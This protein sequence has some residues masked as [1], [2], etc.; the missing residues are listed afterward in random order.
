[1]TQYLPIILASA[2]LA[3]LA[4]P[5]TRWMARR[6][7]MVDQPGLRKAH[8][9]PTPLLGGLAMYAGLIAAFLLLGQPGWVTEGVGILGGATLMFLTGL[10][11][12]R[13]G[14][15][16]R[17]KL[18]AAVVAALFLVA[19]GV[20]VRLFGAWWLDAPIT[21]LWVVG[22]THAANLM[23]NM[24]GLTAGLAAVASVF[25][26]VMAALEG[27][28]LVASLAAALLGATGG[29]LFYNFAPAVSF[30]GDAG[31]LTLGFL[32]A[33]LGIKIEF[34]H[35]PLGATWM[36]PILVLS[37]FIF[38]TTL[39][40]LS[41]LRRGRSPFQGGSDHTSHRLTQLGLSS[42]RAVLT[43]Y[44]GAI[45]LGALAVTL[46]RSPVPVANA[47][48]GLIVAAGVV[49]LIFFERI[50]PRLSGDPLIVL[51]PG[52]GGFAEALRIV[53]P[54]SRNVVVLLAPHRQNGVLSPAH[55]DVVEA[56]AG[57]A[58]AAQAVR[59]LLESGL[60]DDWP[61]AVPSL[62]NALKLHGHVALLDTARRELPP[63]LEVTLRKCKALVLGPGDPGGN[64]APAL[65][66]PALQA[67]LTAARVPIF[68]LTTEALPLP[69]QLAV[70]CVAPREAAAV[71]HKQLLH[72]AAGHAKTQ[73]HPA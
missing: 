5:L 23:D 32:L 64:L 52:S 11:D 69:A 4:T 8:R 38:D 35:F 20:Q 34:R 71:L 29:F 41:R 73:S 66:A 31:A 47:L 1:M 9:S 65:R 15:P 3:F 45:A 7:G 14:M 36:A 67:A 44:L 59:G 21:I 72:H 54:L 37:V 70:T 60:P 17:V 48:F 58:E 63:E 51:I 33:A 13:Y 27:Q 16:A 2:F 24:D 43:M 56:Y 22:I 30:M 19:F 18:L 53:S 61:E 25:F 26:F 55:S 46:T 39:V 10:W 50:E 57:V 28:G 42:P 62:N 49:G 6:L 68:Q 12:D 40:T